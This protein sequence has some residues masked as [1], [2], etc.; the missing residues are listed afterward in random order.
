MAAIPSPTELYAAAM[1]SK[2]AYHTIQAHVENEIKSHRAGA[3]I[4]CILKSR[5][6]HR[7]VVF[8]KN[9]SSGGDNNV[10]YIAFSVGPG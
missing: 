10:V 4:E 7:F 2:L 5:G 6:N 3:N 9:Q 8:Y 1:A